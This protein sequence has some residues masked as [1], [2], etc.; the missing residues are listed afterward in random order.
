MRNTS[1][2]KLACLPSWG[3][4]FGLDAE[5]TLSHLDSEQLSR[6][7]EDY[8]PKTKFLTTI[9]FNQF[10]KEGD[11]EVWK[12]QNLLAHLLFEAKQVR[13]YKSWNP[14][15]VDSVFTESEIADLRVY[16]DKLLKKPQLLNWCDEFKRMYIKDT[17]YLNDLHQTM[18][19]IAERHLNKKLKPT[20]AFL[21]IYGEQGYCPP[22]IDKNRCQ[23]TMDVCIFQDKVWPFFIENKEY[24]LNLNSAL[25]YSGTDQLHWRNKIHENGFCYLVFFHFEE[26]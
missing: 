11:P 24:L 14:F 26:I 1:T 18:V 16:I 12:N 3:S 15:V 21:S 10:L 22:H 4:R 9:E 5:W 25:F 13:K 20:Y 17:V 8:L 19:P 6:F 2:M 23:W 7:L